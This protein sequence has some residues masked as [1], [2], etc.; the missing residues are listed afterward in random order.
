MGLDHARELVSA[1]AND[2]NT[3]GPHSSLGNLAPA[4]YAAGF[5]SDPQLPATLPLRLTTLRHEAYQ[6]IGL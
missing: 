3:A 6:L 2:Y 5:C 4:A 1:W